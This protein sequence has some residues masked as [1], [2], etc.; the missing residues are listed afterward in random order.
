MKPIKFKEQN[1]TVARP[2]GMGED[3]CGDSR[4]VAPATGKRFHAGA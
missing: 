1:L 4:H 3:Q 2:L